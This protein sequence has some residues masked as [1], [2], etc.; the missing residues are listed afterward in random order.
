MSEAAILPVSATGTTVRPAGGWPRAEARWSGPPEISQSAVDA[1]RTGLRLERLVA[2]ILTAR[3]FA[4]LHAAQD[5]LAPKLDGLFD[6]LAM[7]DMEVAVARLQ[8][9]LRERE[10][11][12]LYGDYDVDGTSSIVVLKKALEILG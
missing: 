5:F 12:L 3:G 1:L 9:A 6:P 8:K 11:V 2:A 7:R 4:E 10:P